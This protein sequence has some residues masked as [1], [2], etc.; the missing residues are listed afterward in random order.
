METAHTAIGD[1]MPPKDAVRK[2]LSLTPGQWRA[3]EDL[4]YSRRFPTDQ[5]VLLALVKAGAPAFG[6]E[7]P[8]DGPKPKARQKA[9]GRGR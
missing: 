3:I 1:G 6:F 2:M 5:A 9:R 8:D 4:R 7:L